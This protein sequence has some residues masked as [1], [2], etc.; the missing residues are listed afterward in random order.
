MKQLLTT[1][2]DWL[3]EDGQQLEDIIIKGVSIDSRTVGES[4]LFIPFRGE[5]VNGHRYVESAIE[6]GAAAA[7]WMKDE[8]NPPKDIPLIFVEDPEIALQEMARSYR[9]Q[10]DCTVI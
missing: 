3:K 7:L 6:K 8:P 2:A 1:I 10:L 5:Q 4:H 9:E